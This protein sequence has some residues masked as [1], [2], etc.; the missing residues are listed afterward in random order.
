MSVPAELSRIAVPPALGASAEPAS[1]GLWRDALA[2]LSRDRLTIA[3]AAI[4]A[5]CVVL[6]LLADIIASTL[7]VSA[8]QVDLPHRFQGPS[9]AHWL[10]T[11]EFGR[12]QL[13]RLLQGARVSLGVASSAA[14]INLVLGVSLG[15][16]AAMYGGIADDVFTWLVNT[17]RSIPSL[18]LLLIIAALF[19]VGPA[20]LAVIIGLTSWMGPAR[21]VRGQ[22]L[23]TK[24]S[25]YIT[26]ARAVGAPE[27]RIMLRHVLPNLVPI[28]SVLV[29]IDVGQAILRES[30]LSYL[31]LGVQPPDASWG[32]MLTNAQAY[33][34][35]GPWLV[36]APGAAIT[37]IVWC[38]YAIG[39]GLRDALDPR[40][41]P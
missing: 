3:A 17:M 34:S 32:N 10:G 12:D 18:F 40:L 29:G 4:V 41:A 19:R 14:L 27:L 23:E 30:A 5:V 33:F 31:G 7:G 1:R 35:R 39:D 13:A 8:T 37:L 24:A 20:G 25:E 38:L 9:S 22:A 15:T 28:I 2:R 6:A 26:S 21:L 16:T 36:I 11:D